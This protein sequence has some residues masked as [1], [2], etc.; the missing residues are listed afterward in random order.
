MRW[1]IVEAIIEKEKFD[2]KYEEQFR[3]LNKPRDKR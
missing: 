1:D 2:R 3:L